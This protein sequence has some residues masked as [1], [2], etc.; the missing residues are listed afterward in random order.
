MTAI[1]LSDPS[2]I[3]TLISGL[4]LWDLQLQNYS[5]PINIS[6]PVPLILE[7]L[8]SDPMLWCPAYAHGT[9]STPFEEAE[10]IEAFENWNCRFC[11]LEELSEKLPRHY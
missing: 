4:N 7:F 6:S 8:P 5:N 1:I 11:T 10:L 9:L 3:E 2:S